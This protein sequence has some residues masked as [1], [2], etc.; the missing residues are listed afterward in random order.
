MRDTT[1]PLTKKRADAIIPGDCQGR[2][3]HEGEDGS[4]GSEDEMAYLDE[5]ARKFRTTKEVQFPHIVSA[6]NNT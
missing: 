3:L 6:R 4:I 5:L 1:R 2:F